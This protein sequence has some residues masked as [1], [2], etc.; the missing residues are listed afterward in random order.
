MNTL[1][2]VIPTTGRDTLRRAVKSAEAAADQVLIVADRWT[3]PPWLDAL[4]VDC[5]APGLARN[6]ALPYLTT[7]H[8]GWLDDD[9]VLIPD[10]YRHVALEVHPAADMV[11]HTMWTPDVGPVPRPGWPIDHGNVGISLTMRT[12]VAQA[13]PFIAGPPFTMRGEDFE[14]VR[15]L[16]DKGAP[17]V[18]SHDIAYVARPE[19]VRWPSPTAT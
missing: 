6:A 10:V 16:M 7:T 14:L 9:D 2:V 5:G 4:E 11:I 17:I 19:E 1:T 8:V 15:R 12:S 3:P 18:L 13:E